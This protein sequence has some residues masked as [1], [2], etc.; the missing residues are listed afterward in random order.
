VKLLIKRLFLGRA[1]PKTKNTAHVIVNIAIFERL[2]F[3]EYSCKSLQ[4]LYTYTNFEVVFLVIGIGHFLTLVPS[5]LINF[6][7]GNVQLFC[8]NLKP[9]NGISLAAVF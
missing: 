4:T 3:E 1:S 8:W 7:M 5:P 6:G 9:L 2:L